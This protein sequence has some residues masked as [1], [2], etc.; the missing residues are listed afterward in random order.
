MKILKFIGILILLVIAFFLIAGLVMPKEFTYEEEIVINQP[1]E[2]VFDYIKHLKN[3]DNY[4]T[5]NQIDPN[6]KSTYEGEDGTVGFTTFW[7]S[8]NWQV[9][10]GNQKIVDIKEGESISTEIRLDGWDDPMLAT[11]STEPIGDNQTKV[12][13]KNEGHS[14]YPFNAMA[15]FFDMSDDFEEGLENLKEVLEAQETVVKDDELA[16]LVAQYN[17]TKAA[18]IAEVEGLSEAQL[19]FKPSPDQWSVGQCV[20]HII[21]S[22]KGLLDMLQT[23]MTEQKQISRDSIMVSDEELMGFIV[24]REQK[25]KAPEAIQG[26]NVYKDA[27]TAIKDFTAQREASIDFVNNYSSEQLRNQV[28]E[29]PSGYVDAYQFLSFISGHGTRHTEQI[30]EVKANANFP[31]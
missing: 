4:G 9:G 10:K 18:L 11:M 14:P 19:T 31:K 24:N 23:A 7:E 1:E 27:Q 3:Q 2:Q 15:L 28:L 6:M 29:S 26:E 30:K 22:E 12:T 17:Q 21:K 13:W 8:E 16:A 20:D 5:W 25:A